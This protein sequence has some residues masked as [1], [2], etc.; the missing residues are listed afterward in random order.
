MHKFEP[1]AIRNF[2]S[3]PIKMEGCGDV[4]FKQRAVIEFLIAEKIPPIDIQRNV[5]AVRG[6]KF[7][8]VSTGRL[9]VRQLNQEGCITP[10]DS[11]ER[12]ILFQGRN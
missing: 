10:M 9:W 2:G 6:V 5:Q 4:R 12:K 11:G 1:T 8:N 7:V 3:V